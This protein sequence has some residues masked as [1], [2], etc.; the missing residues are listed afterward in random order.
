MAPT[1]TKANIVVTNDLDHLRN[2]LK[3]LHEAADAA[4][5]DEG[6]RLG[7]DFRGLGDQ[8]KLIS[9]A[10]LLDIAKLDSVAK[11]HL[12][13]AA[14]N[15]DHAAAHAGRVVE[16]KSA[17]ARADVHADARIALASMRTGLHDLSSAV[18]ASRTEGAGR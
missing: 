2:R 8:A 10:I 12:R 16:R 3:E 5:D 6:A 13:N 9:A 18:A 4:L 14:R 11:M 1:I 15:I 17:D 7:N